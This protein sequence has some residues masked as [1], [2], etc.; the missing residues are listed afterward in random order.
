M[1]REL[2]E[3]AGDL[4]VTEREGAKGPGASRSRQGD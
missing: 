3:E 1:G 4:D 2:Y